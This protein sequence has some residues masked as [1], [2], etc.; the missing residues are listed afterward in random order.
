MNL[1]DWLGVNNYPNDE[2][3]ILWTLQL[4]DLLKNCPNG[5]INPKLVDV[6][7]ND[8][9][10][11]LND[12]GILLDEYSAPENIQGEENGG[13]TAAV[14]S[15]GLIVDEF[16]RGASYITEHEWSVNDFLAEIRANDNWF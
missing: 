1:S 5:H 14:F 11:S 12:S 9:S 3:R 8:L 16:F 10:L 13:F 2:Q 6:N 4:A 15:Y 7:P